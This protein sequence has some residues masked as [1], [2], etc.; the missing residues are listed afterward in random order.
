MKSQSS[1]DD[2]P[3]LKSLGF[4]ELA[5]FFLLYVADAS[6]VLLSQLQ[7]LGLRGQMEVDNIVDDTLL[8]TWSARKPHNMFAVCNGRD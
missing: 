8:Q 2:P 3:P 4:A 6:Q 5:R 7:V 1:S